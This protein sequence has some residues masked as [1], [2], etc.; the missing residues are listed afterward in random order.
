MFVISCGRGVVFYWGALVK[1]KSVEIVSLTT[2][3]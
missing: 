1:V 3:R 2:L